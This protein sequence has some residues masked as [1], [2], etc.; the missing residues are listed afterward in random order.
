MI[1]KIFFV[2]PS[3][4]RGGV[5]RVTLN[6]I[7][8]L[9][10]TQL[11][12]FLIICGGESN[13]FIT[14]LNEKVN[15]IELKKSSVRKALPKIFNLIKLEQPKIIF[16]SF[17]HLS[18][19]ILVYNKFLFKKIKTIVRLNS[20]PSNKLDTKLRG[21]IYHLFFSFFLK[22]AN[23]IISQSPEMTE[24][25]SEYYDIPLDRIN[26]IRN[27][28]DIEGVKSL[29]ME[30]PDMHF[31]KRKY[32]IVSIG[33]LSPLKGFDLA[34]QAIN[35]LVKKGFNDYRLY[36]IG[37][38]RDV[39]EDYRHVLEELIRSYNL[40]EYIFLVGFRKNPFPILAQASAFLLS[41]RKEGFPNVVLEALSLGKPSL[42]TD[43]VDLGNIITDENGIVVERESAEAIEDGLIK[44]RTITGRQSKFENFDY[45]SWFLKISEK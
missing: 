41:S 32:N 34:I 31:D 13:D 1:H 29:A 7:N 5:E 42:V 9:D 33:S 17:N 6:I 40:N 39:G 38:N 24:E 3:F 4:R 21:K 23:E 19:P 26:T 14:F 16:T 36:I 11:D 15:V 28:V 12:I 43:C 44:I 27:P 20:L 35:S 10:Y 18:L 25:I 45:N 8:S 37:D 30:S 2:I 22:D